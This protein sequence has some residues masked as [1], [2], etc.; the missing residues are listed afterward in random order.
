MWCGWARFK[1]RTSSV[2]A[3]HLAPPTSDQHTPD[4]SNI[5]PSSYF[6]NSVL[7]ATLLKLQSVLSGSGIDD[8]AYVE[9]LGLLLLWELM[10]ATGTPHPLLKL[11]RGGLTALQLNRVKEFVDA[12]VANDIAPRT[13]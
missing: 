1:T 8:H 11:A 6:E 9:T 12:Q 2:F 10:R 5:L 4:I 7:A 13:A 3:V